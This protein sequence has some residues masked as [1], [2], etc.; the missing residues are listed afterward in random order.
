MGNTLTKDACVSM[1]SILEVT[2]ISYTVRRTSGLMD[3]GW[4]IGRSSHSPPWVTKKA[5]F[6]EKTG[7][8]HIYMHNG[9]TEINEFLHVWRNLEHIYPPSMD[10]EETRVWRK[11]VL[12]QLT[13]LEVKRVS[14]HTSL[15]PSL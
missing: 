3:P 9:K 6:N 12:D 8:W 2:D 7:S 14:E 13:A 15:N 11:K 4:F 1:D 10:E 5:Y